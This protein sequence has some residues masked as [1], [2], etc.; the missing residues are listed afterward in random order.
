LPITQITLKFDITRD[1]SMVGS[2]K[3]YSPD[4][5]RVF[6]GHYEN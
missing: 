5:G 2:I 3:R 1:R 4:R 6:W